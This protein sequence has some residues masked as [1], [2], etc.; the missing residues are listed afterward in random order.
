MEQSSKGFTLIELVIVIV[1]IGILAAI[2]IPKYIDITSESYSAAREGLAGNMSSAS[3]INYAGRKANS[4][5]GVALT[6]CSQIGNLVAG[7]LPSG[8]T[9]ASKALASDTPNTCVLTQTAT[10]TTFDVQILPIS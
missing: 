8:Y 9:V 4:S 5:Y 1:I 6:N 2:A 3:S 10:S 7:G